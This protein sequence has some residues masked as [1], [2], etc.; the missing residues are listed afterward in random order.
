MSENGE[1]GLHREPWAFSVRL[2]TH[3]TG[4]TLRPQKGQGPEAAV[5]LL[6]PLRC[7]SLLHS[8][9]LLPSLT[10]DLCT[11]AKCG[12]SGAPQT[13]F[14]IPG[15]EADRASW[16]QVSTSLLSSCGAGS[17]CTG[18]AAGSVQ[19]RWSVAEEYPKGCYQLF[20]F[21]VYSFFVCLFVCLF[22]R[23]SVSRGG[24][25]REREREKQ[26]LKQAPGSELSAQSR[27][28][29]SNSSTMRL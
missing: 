27:T 22:E 13:H 6:V 19:R 16:S 15:G 10:A 28:W 14:P 2:G 29:G 5:L 7:Q 21:N 9:H 20:F 1:H 12:C 17:R 26:N 18:V 3:E 11:G 24:A 8:V 23:Q 4:G 25:E